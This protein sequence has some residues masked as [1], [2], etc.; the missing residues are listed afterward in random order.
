MQDPDWRER[1]CLV[2]R[3]RA[4]RFWRE[5]TYATIRDQLL[6]ARRNQSEA[7]REAHRQATLRRYQDP[8]ERERQ[9]RLMKAAWS[10]DDGSRRQRQAEVARGINIRAEITEALVRAA[11]DETG[12]IRAA[13]R[14]L[15]CDRSV[16]RRFPH[17]IKA[18]RG[19]PHPRN[20][21]VAAIRPVPGI[22]DVYCLTVPEAG[23]FALEA[24]VFTRN[25]GI[26]VNITPLEPEWRGK[27]TIEISNS[28]PLPAKIYAGEGIAQ[29]VFLRAEAV[30]RTSYGDKKGKYQDQKGLTLPFVV[31]EEPGD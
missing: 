14:L 7:T 19:Q 21:K 24:G 22:H 11:L 20:H 1:Y 12:S 28:T 6:E 23:N 4:L 25:C 8:A 15:G 9:S 31:G 5:E 29:I 26:I 30:C 16:F 27:V 17:L 18:F 3:E 2:Q 10:K 13:A